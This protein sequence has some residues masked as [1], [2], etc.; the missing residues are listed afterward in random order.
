MRRDMDLI[1]DLML[2]I[3]GLERPADIPTGACWH[4]PLDSPEI[5]VPG[6]ATDEIDYHLALI[7]GAGFI[8][9]GGVSAPTGIVL[10]GLTW[11]GHDFVDSVRDPAI[12]RATKEGAVEAGGFSVDLLLALAKG[13]IKKKIEQH[14]GVKLDL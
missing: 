1:R 5:S 3:E 13:L 10:C 9:S 14:T 8:N 12:W 6:H 4:V 11:R 7:R 2:K